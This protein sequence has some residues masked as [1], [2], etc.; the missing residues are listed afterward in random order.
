MQISANDHPDEPEVRHFFAHDNESGPVTTGFAHTLARELPTN[1]RG[2]NG[3]AARHGTRRGYTD[4]WRC[5]DCKEAHRRYQQRQRQ[6]LRNVTSASANE[7]A[8]PSQVT[9]N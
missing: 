8:A 1:T 6:V 4:G 7:G 9:Q 3:M 5:D 2:L